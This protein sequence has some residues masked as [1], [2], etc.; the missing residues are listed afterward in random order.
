MRLCNVIVKQRD[1]QAMVML[2]IVTCTPITYAS[3]F[4]VEM[5]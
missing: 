3:P 1:N 4:S 2:S 5:R